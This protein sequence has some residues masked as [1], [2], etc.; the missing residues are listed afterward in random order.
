MVDAQKLKKG[1]ACKRFPHP[2]ATL[3]NNVESFTV[4]VFDLV[5]LHQ[6]SELLFSLKLHPKEP[7]KVKNNIDIWFVIC[8]LQL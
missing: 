8:L 7:E 5:H 4:D 1:S 6:K 2:H 3:D